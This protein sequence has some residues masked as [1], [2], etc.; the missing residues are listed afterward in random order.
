MQSTHP[1]MKLID[2]LM[3]CAEDLANALSLVIVSAVVL[4]HTVVSRPQV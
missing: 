1:L 3:P 4:L 2:V